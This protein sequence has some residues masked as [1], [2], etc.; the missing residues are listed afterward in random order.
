MKYIIH[1]LNLPHD[2]IDYICSFIFYTLQ[3]CIERNKKNIKFYLVIF[4]NLKLPILKYIHHEQHL[5]TI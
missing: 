5:C 3:Q 4:N 1:L 2:T